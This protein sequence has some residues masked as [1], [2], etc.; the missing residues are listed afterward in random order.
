MYIQSFLLK[1]HCNVSSH[2]VITT[3]CYL[4][5][6]A[7]QNAQT[8]AHHRSIIIIIIVIIIALFLKQNLAEILQG[9]ANHISEIGQPVV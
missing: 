1:I 9:F 4:V 2:F 6:S 8:L 3:Q 7:F 5:K